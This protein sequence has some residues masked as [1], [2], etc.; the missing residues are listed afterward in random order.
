MHAVSN[1]C[2]EN[3]HQWK[4]CNMCNMHC[5][6][7]CFCRKGLIPTTVH[8][9]KMLH[10]QLICINSP[11]YLTPW[12][13]SINSPLFCF[14][15]SVQ[16]IWHFVLS[17]ASDWLAL[18]SRMQREHL[19]VSAERSVLNLHTGLS[20]HNHSYWI[21][22]KTIQDVR[23]GSLPGKAAAWSNKPDQSLSSFFIIINFFL[24]TS[25]EPKQAPA[26]TYWPY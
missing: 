10:K 24:F 21:R 6:S 15:C 8:Y 7:Y 13:C 20:T 14:C 5:V 12:S 9:S 3:V 25:G 26:S 4:G 11:H 23:G 22:N 19:S 1:L 2:I 18:H 17:L 16:I